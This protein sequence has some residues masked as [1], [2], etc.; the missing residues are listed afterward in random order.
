MDG[1]EGGSEGGGGT[2]HPVRNVARTSLQFLF[3][4]KVSGDGHLLLLF[5]RA[6]FGSLGS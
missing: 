2:T 6:C 5:G 3:M 4:S 1:E